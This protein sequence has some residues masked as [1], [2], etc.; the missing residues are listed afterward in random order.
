MIIDLHRHMWSIQERFPDAYSEVPGHEPPPPA[1]FDWK[2]TASKTIEEM[3][4]A[5]VDK[6][7]LFVADF[8]PRLGPAPLSI[9]EENRL[10]AEAAG[11][12]PDRIVPFYG[13]A[14]RRPGAT[15]KFERAIKEW[16]FRG[17]KFHPTVG[18]F[19]HD[20]ECYPIYELCAS[21][22]IPVLFHSGPG[23]HPRLYSIYTHPFEYDQVAADFPNLIMIMGHAGDDW[24]QEC[25]TIARSHPNM[26]L[27]LSEWQG[28]LR[29]RAEESI[30]AIDKMRN[31]L[32]I[33][34][35]VWGSDFPG[36]RGTMPLTDCVKIFQGLPIIGDKFDVKFTDN[37]VE[38]ILGLNA[39]RILGLD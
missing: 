19:P 32:G 7:T 30:W 3:D 34:R 8:E 4:C 22:G 31:V 14:P 36:L 2:E 38:A 6:T 17:I 26:V 13:I 9:D 28:R 33:E 24:W 5:G 16:G 35:V 20:R 10:I 39:A 23:I 11:L 29:D 27:E 1:S 21:H 18:Y 37:D 15:D 12:F 25:I